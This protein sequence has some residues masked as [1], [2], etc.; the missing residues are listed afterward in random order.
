[1]SVSFFTEQSEQLSGSFAWF[2]LS[3]LSSCSK[4]QIR[5]GSTLVD[6]SPC[7][8]VFY[9]WLGKNRRYPFKNASLLL[10][11]S[12][13]NCWKSGEIT[14]TIFQHCMLGGGEVRLVALR[15]QKHQNCKF[16]PR[17]EIDALGNWVEEY[18]VWKEHDAYTTYFVKNFRGK[19]CRVCAGERTTE[20]FHLLR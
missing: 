17:C 5:A 13:F 10:L 7:D 3:T 15:A 2:Q 12:P 9:N 4:L 11:P 14:G 19:C 6:K 8:S 20:E 18:S 16:C 1:M